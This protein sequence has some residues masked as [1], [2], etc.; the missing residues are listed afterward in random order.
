MP[1]LTECHYC[2]APAD[3]QCTSCD[4]WICEDDHARIRDFDPFCAPFCEDRAA[5]RPVCDRCG[6]PAVR[7]AAGRWVHAEAADA[8]FC[9]LVMTRA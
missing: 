9:Q 5:P 7:D 4:R 1:D 6:M 2:G 3:R 8:A